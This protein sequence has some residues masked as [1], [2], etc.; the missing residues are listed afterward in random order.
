[1]QE[2]VLAHHGDLYQRSQHGWPKL[3]IDRGEV[4][5]ASVN[6]A[7]LGVGFALEVEQCQAE[8]N[9]S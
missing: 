5:L 1:V 2:Q 9:R 4:D 3:R 7:P 8:V 6:R